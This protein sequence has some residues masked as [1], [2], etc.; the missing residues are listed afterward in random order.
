MCN[1]LIIKSHWMQCFCCVLWTKKSV[2]PENS[3]NL[4]LEASWKIDAENPWNL[5]CVNPL[6]SDTFHLSA[7]LP[8]CVS[9]KRSFNSFH[10]NVKCSQ[11][12]VTSVTCGEWFTKLSTFY[13]TSKVSYE[14]T[15]CRLRKFS[16]TIVYFIPS[17]DWDNHGL[18]KSL[19][20]CTYTYN[21]D[22]YF[23]ISI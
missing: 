14:K 1:G 10:I 13:L 22:G 7:Q 20:T 2:F 11:P 3:W 4:F 16:I 6:G 12:P 19:S 17:W 23:S 18:D 15:L 5:F 9:E 21:Q 8:D